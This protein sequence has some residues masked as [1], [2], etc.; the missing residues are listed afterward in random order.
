[1]S[2]VLPHAP[3]AKLLFWGTV[4]PLLPVTS[5]DE[6][7]TVSLKESQLAWR[8]GLKLTLRTAV[9]LQLGRRFYLVEPAGTR[10]MGQ[11]EVS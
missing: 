3:Q 10:N 8:P 11:H 7:G 9:D 4:P 1:M 2:W 6:D 5:K